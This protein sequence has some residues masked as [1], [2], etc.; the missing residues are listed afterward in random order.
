MIKGDVTTKITLD[1][2]WMK[3][4]ITWKGEFAFGRDTSQHRFISDRMTC[5]NLELQF[6]PSDK[7]H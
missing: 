6:S 1:M 2:I 7:G 5:Q 4:Q 3:P